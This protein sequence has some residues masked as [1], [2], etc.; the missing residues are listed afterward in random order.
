MM[1]TLKE[2]FQAVVG[3]L[4]IMLVIAVVFAILA[5]ISYVGLW[6]YTA[7]KPETP[8]REIQVERNK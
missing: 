8:S 3:T 4:Q 1:L 2:M 5:G 6:A 7:I